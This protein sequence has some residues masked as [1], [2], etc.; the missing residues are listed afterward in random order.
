MPPL[1][2]ED[3]GTPKELYYR[4]AQIGASYQSRSSSRVCARFYSTCQYNAQEL[5][6]IFVT[7]D[8][9]TNE[10]DDDDQPSSHLKPPNSS[11]NPPFQFFVHPRQNINTSPSSTLYLQKPFV[12][13]PIYTPLQKPYQQQHGIQARQYQATISLPVLPKQRFISVPPVA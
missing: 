1:S 7:E 2:Q 12:A 8:V 5:I 10:I 13:S 11:V 4:A 9:Q 6:N 3:E